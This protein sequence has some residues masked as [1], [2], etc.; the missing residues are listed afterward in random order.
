MDRGM[1][2][3]AKVAEGHS[4]AD[5]Q[6][7]IR[8]IEYWIEAAA[9]RSAMYLTSQVRSTHYPVNERSNVHLQPL[10]PFMGLEN[11]DIRIQIKK[12]P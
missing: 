10:A 12:S 5:R 8:R 6:S 4:L 1:V 2:I 3:V 11:T 9:R 7:H